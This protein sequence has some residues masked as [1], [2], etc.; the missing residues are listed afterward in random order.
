MAQRDLKPGKGAHF[1][2]TQEVLDF[3]VATLEEI[4]S[5]WDSDVID[6]GEAK[7]IQRQLADQYEGWT[8]VRDKF[9]KKLYKGID[10]QDGQYRVTLVLNSYGELKLDIRQWYLPE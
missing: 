5:V 4:Q 9:G 1:T 6:E 8:S 2:A 10:F 7:E 3:L